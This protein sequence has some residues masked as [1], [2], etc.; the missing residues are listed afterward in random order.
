MCSREGIR[1]FVRL[2]GV[3]LILALFAG[4]LEGLIHRRSLAS[5]LTET[6]CESEAFRRQELPE[7]LY[8]SLREGSTDH[9]A[10]PN[11]NEDENAD[12]A[13][14]DGK[15]SD[16]PGDWTER[17]ALTMLAADFK[18]RSIPDGKSLSD[19][20]SACLTY[21]ENACHTLISAYRAVW[22]DVEYFP[23]AS[24]E[25]S[26]EDTWGARR[27][28]GGERSHEGTDL[29]GKITE[30]GYYPIVSMTDGVVEQKGWLPLG[31]Y[32]IGIRAPSGGYFYYAHLSSYERDFT[33]GETIRAGDILGY[34]GDTGYGAEGTFGRFPVHLHLG[35]YLTTPNH[36]ELS[37]NPYSLL[38]AFRKK[39]RKYQY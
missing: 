17:L 4:S 6:T 38:L 23:V 30:S 1:A 21:K 39:I 3:L 9:S 19:R 20:H 13:A 14:S 35:I 5:G 29:F 32:R 25:I 2:T 22:A 16:F 24:S 18:P 33:P 28:Y 7:K 12:T 15:A 10:D 26:F 34:M 11:E 8:Q 37:V 36:S 27:D 31:G